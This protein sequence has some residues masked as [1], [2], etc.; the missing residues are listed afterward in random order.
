VAAA[1][2][3]IRGAE[4]R[5][6]TL[7]KPLR[8]TRH[9]DSGTLGAAMTAGLG[10]GAFASLGEAAD[11]LVALRAPCSSLLQIPVTTTDG[12]FGKYRELYADLK[13][14]NEWPITPASPR[15]LRDFSLQA[16]RPVEPLRNPGQFG[17][18]S[19]HLALSEALAEARIPASLG[20]HDVNPK[21]AARP[22]NPKTS[23][24]WK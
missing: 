21:G 14:F 3:P 7:G 6:D 5:A 9:L 22:Q 20:N 1:R 24:R 11:R 13:P 17:P 23:W 16:N 18:K 12:R 10:A 4:I 19:A 8:R 15:R 2:G